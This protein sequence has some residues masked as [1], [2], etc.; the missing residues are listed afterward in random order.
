MNQEYQK[1]AVE[2]SAAEPGAAR[3]ELPDL[4]PADHVAVVAFDGKR[5]DLLTGWSGSREELDRELS[6][7]LEAEASAAVESPL[8]FEEGRPAGGGHVGRRGAGKTSEEAPKKP[9]GDPARMNGAARLLAC[10]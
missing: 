5:L 2:W 4:A 9:R 6:R 10:P 7:W 3:G 8:L 1:R